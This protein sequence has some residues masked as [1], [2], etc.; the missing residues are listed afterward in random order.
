MSPLHA[1]L[2]G[3]VEGLTEFVPVSSTGHLILVDR[4]LGHSGPAI[5]AFEVVIQLGALLACVLYYRALL[6]SMLRGLV[7]RERDATRLFLAILCAFVPTA[8]AGLVLHK[9][10][11]AVLFGKPALVAGALMT[12]GLVMIAIDLWR[13]GRVPLPED[14]SSVTPSRGFVVGL[15]QCASLWPGTS[16]S[17]ASIVGGKLCGLSTRVATDFA[18][19]IG[20]PTL[21]AACLFKLVK[22]RHVLVTEI[23]AV[24]LAV[25]LGVSFVISWIVIAAFLKA[26]GKTGLVPFGIYRLAIGAVVLVAFSV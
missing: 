9:R 8:L 15:F 18:F 3:L 2:L 25:G 12:G 19:L 22:A 6:L 14:L 23:G 5:D 13:R 11:E 26:L 10:I 21:G 4:F 7:R 20:I 16:R 17:M 1:A 24:P